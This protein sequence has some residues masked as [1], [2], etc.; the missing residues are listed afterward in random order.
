MIVIDVH[1]DINKQ[2]S[3]AFCYVLVPGRGCCPDLVKNVK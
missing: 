3:L 1:S 2:P